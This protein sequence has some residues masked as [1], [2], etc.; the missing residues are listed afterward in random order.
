M[1][2]EKLLHLMKQ[3]KA[4]EKIGHRYPGALR[5]IDQ[6]TGN[7][8]KRTFRIK[9][10]DLTFFTNR[11][12]LHVISSGTGLKTYTDAFENSPEPSADPYIPDTEDLEFTFTVTDPLGEYLERSVVINLP[13]SLNPEDESCVF[14]PLDIPVFP[15]PAAH[16]SPN[17]SIIRASL[18]SMEDMTAQI[19]VQ[20]AM[21]RIKNTEGDLLMSGISDLRGEAAV[22]IPGIPIT[23]F[24]QGTELPHGHGHEDDDWTATGSVVETQT[25]ATLEVIVT[26]DTPWPVNP[27]LMEENHETWRRSFRVEGSGENTDEYSLEL[28]TANT[29]SIK[30]FIDLT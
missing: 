7:Q 27:S 19:P 3:I 21:M 1:V 24:S 22:I 16:L 26:P 8:V 20:G 15:A 18:Y 29:Q 10:D 23:T 6:I 4:K 5:I 17:W 12:F 2:T 9:S 30:L 13:R 28:K 11:S 25:Q 14:N